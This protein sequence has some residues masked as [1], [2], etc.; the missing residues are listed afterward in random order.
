MVLDADSTVELDGW[1]RTLASVCKGGEET[2]EQENVTTPVSPVFKHRYENIESDDPLERG[3]EINKTKAKVPIPTPRN[4][5]MEK[6]FFRPL[7]GVFNDYTLSDDG[8][9]IIMPV[10]NNEILIDQIN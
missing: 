4:T 8:T 5:I 7:A 6:V 9:R 3:R 10:G 1:Y 2:I